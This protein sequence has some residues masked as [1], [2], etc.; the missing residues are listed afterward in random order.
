VNKPAYAAGAAGIN[1]SPGALDVCANEW[2][3]V[4]NAPVNVAFGSEVNYCVAISR[5]FGHSRVRYVQ[6]GELHSRVLQR[7]FQVAQI[8]GISELIEYNDLVRRVI[9]QNLMNEIGADESCSS[10]DENAHG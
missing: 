6:T 3:G 9:P 4:F 1:Y 7:P 2:S 8:T 10:G 5:D